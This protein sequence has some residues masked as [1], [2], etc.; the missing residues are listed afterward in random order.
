M[1]KQ[2]NHDFKKAHQILEQLLNQ[3]KKGF[4]P[5]DPVA[6][7][8]EKLITAGKEEL[9]DLLAQGILDINEE[10]PAQDQKQEQPKAPLSGGSPQK[11]RR[12]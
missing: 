8:L 1:S 3:V 9:S 5:N 7:Y 2:E 12:S 6:Q 11:R 4:R 10:S